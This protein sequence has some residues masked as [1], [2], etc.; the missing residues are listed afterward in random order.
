MSLVKLVIVLFSI[1]LITQLM[2]GCHLKH[3]HVKRNPG[4]STND[5]E[6]KYIVFKISYGQRYSPEL[7]QVN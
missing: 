4:S 3:E 6:V 1:L 2:F 5:S 7:T